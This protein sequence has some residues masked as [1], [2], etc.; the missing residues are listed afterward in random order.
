[1]KAAIVCFSETGQKTAVRV[2]GAL[3]DTTDCELYS[4]TKYAVPDERFVPVADRLPVWTK[5]HWSYDLLVYVGA[6]GIAVRAIAP[7]VAKKTTDPAVVVLDEMARYCIPLLSGHLGGANAFAADI[8]AATGSLPIVTTATDIHARFAVDVFAK[9]NELIIDSMLLAKEVSAALLAGEKIGVY[10]ELPIEDTKLPK[11]LVLV[12]TKEEAASLPLGLYIGVH[13]GKP[14]EKTLRLIPK[15]LCLGM[16]C[17]RDTLQERT[18][19]L[20]A[21]I[22]KKYALDMRAFACVASIDLKKDEAALHSLAEDLQVPFICYRAD[23]L[24]VLEGDFTPSAF[25]SSITSVDNVCERSA[26]LAAKGGQLIIKKTPQDGVTA[27]VA[28]INRR[29]HFE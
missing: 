19:A 24:A 22:Q 27:A 29:I 25:V 20:F 17:R 18:E 11:G 7:S 28:V 9:K 14:F 23:E 6:V 8:A 5:E 13:T 1:M 26:V 16:G 15:I 12:H 4:K 3:A 10:S 2:A 21:E